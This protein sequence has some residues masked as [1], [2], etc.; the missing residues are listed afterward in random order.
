MFRHIIAAVHFNYNLYRAVKLN[1]DGSEQV[2]IV[3]PKFKNGKATVKKVRVKPNYGKDTY[4]VSF[5]V[6]YA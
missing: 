3:Y 1:D 4:N 6:S 5:Y 2:K